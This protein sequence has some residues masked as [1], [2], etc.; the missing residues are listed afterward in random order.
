MDSIEKSVCC[1]V[2]GFGHVELEESVAVRPTGL[3]E[4]AGSGLFVAGCIFWLF[5]VETL[6]CVGEYPSALS[7]RVLSAK[8]V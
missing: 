5:T 3:A 4:V 7:R 2:D 8:L 1:G 6:V